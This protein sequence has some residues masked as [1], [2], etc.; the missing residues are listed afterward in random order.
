[1]ALLRISC[2]GLPEEQ[3][4]LSNNITT[5][6]TATFGRAKRVQLGSFVITDPVVGLQR[7]FTIPGFPRTTK[8]IVGGGLLRRFSVIFDY[9]RKRMILEPNQHL[10]DPFEFDMSGAWIVSDKPHSNGFRIASV[11]PN[12]PA[13]EAGLRAGD[14]IVAVDEQPA[15][16]L[17]VEQLTLE[18]FR[19]EGRILD[20]KVKRENEIVERRLKLRRLI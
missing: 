4:D 6:I 19:Q 12:A 2:P 11:M 17:T 5:T 15:E 20:L 14:V 13:L 10:H 16:E 18:I 3:I 9:E 1:V 7:E 8:G